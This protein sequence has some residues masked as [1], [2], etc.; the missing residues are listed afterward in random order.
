MLVC[1]SH[2][3]EF[4]NVIMKRPHASYF[5]TSTRLCLRES[6]TRAIPKATKGCSGCLPANRRGGARFES[7]RTMVGCSCFSE[8]HI[9]NTGTMMIQ[10]A[11]CSCCRG[12]KMSPRAGKCF[13][14]TFTRGLFR[15]RDADCIKVFF[16]FCFVF[17]CSLHSIC[18][19][20]GAM[21]LPALPS[22]SLLHARNLTRPLPLSSGQQFPAFQ[23]VQLSLTLTST[24]NQTQCR[25]CFRP[26]VRQQ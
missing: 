25:A 10:R 26:L 19:L 21:Y 8:A 1:A 13:R 16:L 12:C 24:L 15:H 22:I 2:F 4:M 14:S 18:P 23:P 11:S 17:V 9:S 7:Q 5:M 20:V 6:A 3:C